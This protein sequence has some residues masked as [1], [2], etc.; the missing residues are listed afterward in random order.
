[1]KGQR[2]MCEFNPGVSALTALPNRTV[3][4]KARVGCVMTI[5]LSP[6]DSGFCQNA[7]NDGLVVQLFGLVFENVRGQL[8]RVAGLPRGQNSFQATHPTSQ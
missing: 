2:W 4:K 7:V 1:M 6:L 8:Q 3:T 5:V